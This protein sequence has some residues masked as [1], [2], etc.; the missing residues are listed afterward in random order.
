MEE[1]DQNE[2]FTCC[3]LKISLAVETVHIK[4]LEKSFM[5]KETIQSCESIGE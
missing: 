5:V 1:Q 4:T 2:I 3:Q